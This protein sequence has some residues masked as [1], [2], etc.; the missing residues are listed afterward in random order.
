MC[1]NCGMIV[2]YRTNVFCG[3][4]VPCVQTFGVIYVFLPRK[5][6]V[7]LSSLGIPQRQ[8]NTHSAT[9]WFDVV[10]IGNYEQTKYVLFVKCWTQ[11]VAEL[12]HILWTIKSKKDGTTQT[13]TQVDVCMHCGS[14]GVHKPEGHK[15]CGT[16]RCTQGRWSQP[17]MGWSWKAAAGMIGQAPT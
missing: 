3:L 5:T 12:Y 15:L 8:H 14:I 17:C 9:H 2:H 16:P 13:C 1:N 6:N 7:S 10:L 4:L 11:V